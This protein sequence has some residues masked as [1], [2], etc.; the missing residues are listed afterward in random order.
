MSGTVARWIFYIL[1]VVL[2]ILHQDLWLW[3]ESDLLLGFP[4]GLY[5]HVMYCVAVA[6]LMAFMV[7]YA[8]PAELDDEEGA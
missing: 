2:F 8:W 1:L 6:T 3:N 5:Y 7:D 4:I